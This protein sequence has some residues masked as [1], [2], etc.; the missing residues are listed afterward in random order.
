MF[1]G[2]STQ[3]IK[4]KILICTKKK[5]KVSCTHCSRNS[6]QRTALLLF[7]MFLQFYFLGGVHTFS[8]VSWHRQFESQLLTG[9]PCSMPGYFTWNFVWTKWH[10]D[11]IFF[12]TLIF[13]WSF[14]V[15]Y[16]LHNHLSPPSTVMLFVKLLGLISFQKRETVYFVLLYLYFGKVIKY[17]SHH[18]T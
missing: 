2:I 14:I 13:L 9:V 10:W 16:M 1:C 12:D 6:A 5:V 15:P 7:F 3:Y 11:S 4:L 8:A 17:R 18:T